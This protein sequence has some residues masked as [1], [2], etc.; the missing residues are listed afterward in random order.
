[1]RPDRAGGDELPGDARNP[2]I[3][4]PG[5]KVD[6]EALHAVYAQQPEDDDETPVTVR[7]TIGRAVSKRLDR[8]L[9]DRIPFLSR[10]SLQRL[11]REE[12]VTVNGRPGKASTRVRGGDEV[13]AILPPPPS[14]ELAAEPI[15]LQVVYED[16]DLVVIDKHDGIIVHPARG[17][18]SG[19]VING[20]A[21]HFTH[22]SG[23]GLSRVG[24]EAARPGVVH[25]LDRHTTGLL[26]FAKSETAHWRLA[27]QF[28][29]R[30]TQKRYL[31][32]VHGEVEPLADVIELPLGK[33]P[34]VR[35]KH[36]VRWDHS[37]K[38]STTVY[39]VRE[40]YRGF[41]LLELDL[42]TGRTHQ[43]RVHLAHLGWPLVGDDLYGGRAL[44]I[45]DVTGPAAAPPG[46]GADDPLIGR[47][48]LHATVLAFTHPVT[49]APLVFHS[50]LPP[51]MRDLIRLLR[52]HRFIDAPKL[53]GAA[54]DLATM[55]PPLSSSS[56]AR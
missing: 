52:E 5:G 23:G 39:H 47:Q 43:I 33:H 36:A 31:G 1:M 30:E 34:T 18:D 20:L 53:P 37:G 10:T 35:E 24:E 46:R 21:W 41:T 54:I 29:R 15:P 40:R 26:V 49:R 25:R 4:S 19:T 22:R 48:A 16:D 3:L 13:V 8:Y 55:I 27:R 32:V 7:F 50:T 38:P 11:I 42:R 45:G 17:N 56:P 14:S 51:D 6:P 44:S 2:E 12:A 9:V 28:E